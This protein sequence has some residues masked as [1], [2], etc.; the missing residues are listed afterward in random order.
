MLI[1]PI[2]SFLP[3]WILFS[4]RG[5][6]FPRSGRGY[7]FRF[8]QCIA[9]GW[10]K[11]PI[12]IRACLAWDSFLVLS[13]SHPFLDPVGWCSHCGTPRAGDTFPGLFFSLSYTS[14][15]LSLFV[16]RALFCHD[17]WLTEMSCSALQSGFW[18][19]RSNS[20]SRGSW[21]FSE[22]QK[23]PS[24][25]SSLTDSS[26]LAHFVPLVSSFKLWPQNGAKAPPHPFCGMQTQTLDCIWESKTHGIEL[27]ENCL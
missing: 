18:G 5:K 24:L 16:F 15:L 1:L 11:I 9:S 25:L 19:K 21:T 10:V 3:F 13:L 20:C 23:H 26:T 17:F 4:N 12:M 27:W 14:G 22:Y 6:S 8:L 7:T 2:S